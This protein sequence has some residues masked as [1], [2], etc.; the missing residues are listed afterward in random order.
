MEKYAA[1][2]NSHLQRYRSGAFV[3][4]GMA[5]AAM[6]VGV[7]A[8]AAPLRGGLARVDI[9]PSQPVTLAG[10]ESRKE[11]SQ[12][13]HDPLSARAIALEKD[14]TK[15]LIISTD[16][17]GFYSGTAE[18]IRKAILERNGL[19]TTELL[20]GAIHTHSAP[21]LT[22]DGTRGHT[23]NVRYTKWLQGK[24]VQLAG[25]ALSKLAP[26]ELGM[27]SG[28]SPVGV[29]RRE[30]T[31]D[32]QGQ[33]TIVL[34]RNTEALIDREVQVLKLTRPGQNALA[35]VLF[36]F[37][38]HSTSLGPK[39]YLVSGDIHGLAEQLL[40]RYWGENTV[41]AGF[42]GA[43]GN[44]DP[45]VRVLPEFRTNNGWVP[46]P[47]LMGTMLGEEVARVTESIRS[48]TNEGQISARIET[49]QLPGKESAG[50]SPGTKPFNVTVACVG[51]IGFVGWGGEVF[52]E[53]GRD[54]KKES[55]FKQTFIF[56]HCNGTAG[57]VPIKTAYEEGGYEVRTSSFAPGAGELLGNETVRLLQELK[58]QRQGQAR[59]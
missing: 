57:Y 38:T 43:S 21:S 31:R 2:V 37:A 23:N 17:L 33:P 59:R 4:V 3:L 26:V 28:A 14:G 27:G 10:Y 1:G 34:G 42:A 41:A 46:E 49:V 53:I 45:W 39:N 55:P 56:T 15:L 51:D 30:L 12:G 24:L 44:I 54:V 19:K 32:P 29:N 11:L 5:S 18:T 36:A 52:N 35:G 20:L 47:V 16:N 22:L 9:T 48:S 7:S 40:E 8:S 58:A 50:T 6:F 13:V 25:E